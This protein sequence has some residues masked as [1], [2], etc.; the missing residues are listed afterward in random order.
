MATSKNFYEILGAKKGAAETEIKQAYRK[1]ALKWHPDRHQGS[2]KKEAEQK[3]KEIN[4]AYEVLRD[5][6]KRQT[7]DQFGSSAFEQGGPAGPGGPFSGGFRQ[8]PF[9]Y[10]YSTGGNVNMEDLFGGF[11][12]PFDI[13]EQFFGGGSFSG[14][15]TRQRSVYRLTID[16]MEAANGVE[17][18]VSIEGKRK[19]IKIPR[20]IDD[21]MRIRF[22][23]FDIVV[24]VRSHKIFQRQGQNIIVDFPI[25]FSQA[26]LGTTVN[27]PTVD[28]DVNLRIRPG[29]QP[30]TLLRLR[31]RG[32]Y[33][34]N[35]HSR[36]DQYVRL[37]VKIPAN[38]TRRQKELLKELE[39]E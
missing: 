36:G 8:G 4:Q 28:G 37:K 34:P 25:T 18:E 7:Y 31:G 17:K 22:S 26:A 39:E 11:S 16:F 15:R 13:F 27:V 38:L 5:P 19:K 10:T 21:G 29:T 2:A 9:T 24:S 35:S 6:Q 14:R 12:D 20:G 32:L 33:Y 23:N 1:Q 30:D 3:F